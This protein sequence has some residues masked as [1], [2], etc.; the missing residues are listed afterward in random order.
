MKRIYHPYTRWE[1]VPAGLWRKRSAD[2]EARLLQEAIVFTGN[3]A[4]YGRWMRR[5]TKRWRYSCEHNLTDLSM[6][7]KAWLGHAACCMAIGCPEHITRSA[8][9][10]LSREQQDAA[11]LQAERA[12]AAWEAVQRKHA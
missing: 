5:V 7:R 2:E 1:E 8:W 3:A 6:N 9:W 12:I 4:L 10:R 11:N